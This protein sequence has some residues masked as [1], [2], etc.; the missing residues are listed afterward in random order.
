MFTHT[1]SRAL[2]R[3][4]PLPLAPAQMTA[5]ERCHRDALM[6]AGAT[7]GRGV[8]YVYPTAAV[9]WDGAAKRAWIA[10]DD[11]VDP[12]DWK[13]ILDVL[14]MAGWMIGIPGYDDIGEPGW[15]RVS[16]V[17]VWD[18]TCP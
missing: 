18:L 13:E 11:D 16:R 14:R 1:A 17:W 12:A 8:R 7:L 4:G 5:R 15:D 3:T 10:A 6:A 2:V 9:I